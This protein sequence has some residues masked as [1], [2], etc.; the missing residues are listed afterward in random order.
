MMVALF[1]QMIANILVIEQVLVCRML[2]YSCPQAGYGTRCDE[3]SL[4]GDGI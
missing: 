4:E 2:L 1:E 3:S